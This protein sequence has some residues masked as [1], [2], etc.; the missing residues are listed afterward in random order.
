MRGSGHSNPLMDALASV[1]GPWIF[2]QSAN[3]PSGCARGVIDAARYGDFY[4]P[5][6]AGTAEAAELG[7]SAGAAGAA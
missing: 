1:A 7:R 6:A 5:D 2:L 4:L 3:Q